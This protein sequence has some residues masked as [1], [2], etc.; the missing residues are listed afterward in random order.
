MAVRR[1]FKRLAF[2]HHPD[3][4]LGHPEAASRFRRVCLAYAILNGKQLPDASP[5][6]QARSKNRTSWRRPKATPPPPPRP[7]KFVGGAAI[8]YPTPEEI[9][10][11]DV[12]R[13][14]GS[15]RML[16]F[17]VA[18]VALVVGC[19]WFFQLMAERS[20]AA[21]DPLRN[22]GPTRALDRPWQPSRRLP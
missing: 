11:L 20:P 4:N 22:K 5:P 9:A 7:E 10:A 17:V 3:H 21:P 14:T 8:H 18:T 16:I 19:L 1:A 12:P 15:R 2:Q 6:D 13:L